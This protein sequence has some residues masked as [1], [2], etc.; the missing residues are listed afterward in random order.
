VPVQGPIKL[1]EVADADEMFLAGSSLPVV[2]V[3]AWDGRPV[4]CGYVGTG[5]LLLRQMM[6]NDMKPPDDVESSEMHT[7]VPYGM[8]TGMDADL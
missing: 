2:P 6:L 3:I 5:V 8:L 1:Q 4:G 7:R